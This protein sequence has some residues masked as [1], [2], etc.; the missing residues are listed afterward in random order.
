MMELRHK[1]RKLAMAENS[2]EE[3]EELEGYFSVQ[4]KTKQF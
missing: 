2:I 1:E 3:F 4:N